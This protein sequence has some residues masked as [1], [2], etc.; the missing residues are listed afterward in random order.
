M[1]VTRWVFDVGGSF[2]YTFAQNPDRSG[3]DSFWEFPLRSAEVEVLGSDQARLQ[4]DGVNGAK[5]QLSFTGISGSMMRTLQ[6]FYLRKAQINNCRDHLYST[7]PQFNCYILSFKP[8]I[9]PSLFNEDFWALQM[10]LIKI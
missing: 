4:L 7:T 9:R 10:V 8:T 2:Q 3:G 6:D 1:S 5:R